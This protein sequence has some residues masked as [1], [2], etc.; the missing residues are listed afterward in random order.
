MSADSFVSAGAGCALRCVLRVGGLDA[1][2]NKK[3]RI[4]GDDD[5]AVGDDGEKKPTTAAQRAKDRER[6][7]AA[8]EKMAD[9]MA[10]IASSAAARVA[11]APAG[12]LVPMGPPIKYD[13][14]TH[15]KSNNDFL[16][17]VC[18]LSDDDVAK[19]SKQYPTPDDVVFLELADL[20][21]LGV[22]ENG[23]RR[24]QHY[25]KRYD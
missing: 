6:Q 4:E 5:D 8:A 15:F 10:T 19:I 2:K 17:G 23:A 1:V 16:K 7:L 12:V 18:K 14:A 21:K 20:T 22:S 25:R 9:A 24:F 11:A 13:F 3:R